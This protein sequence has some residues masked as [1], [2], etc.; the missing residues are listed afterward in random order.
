MEILK[1]ILQGGHIPPDK[2]GFAGIAKIIAKNAELEQDLNC[3]HHTDAKKRELLSEILQQE[4]DTTTSISLPFHTDFG[5][6]I[7][8]GK[9]DF[10]NKNSMF[11][12]LGGVYF[13][14]NV[15]VG[16]NVTFASLNH[17]V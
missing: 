9:H 2:E 1:R 17:T 8:L 6:H 4:I 15:L 10:I 7:F 12:D 13:G 14:D 3:N 11:V 16:P 5:P